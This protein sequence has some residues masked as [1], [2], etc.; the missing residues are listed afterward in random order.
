M[1]AGAGASLEIVDRLRASRE[2][3]VALM[4]KEKGRL[5]DWIRGQK[6]LTD[7]TVK[8][9]QLNSG[10]GS[11]SLKLLAQLAMQR[12]AFGVG[13]KQLDLGQVR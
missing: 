9:A 6:V 12:A 7:R 3:F 13:S 10:R 4:Q 1:R 8:V 2:K 5:L 11:K